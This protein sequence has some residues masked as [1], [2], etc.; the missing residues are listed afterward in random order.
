L[1]YLYVQSVR[2]ASRTSTGTT[3]GLL[4]SGMP[5]WQ[6]TGIKQGPPGP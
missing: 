3:T 4:S 1:A 6:Q 5:W 2:S